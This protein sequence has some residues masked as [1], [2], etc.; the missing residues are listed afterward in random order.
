LLS[1][2][3]FRDF[4]IFSKNVKTFFSFSNHQIL[5]K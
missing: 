1:L 5:E 2:A 4:V 3:K